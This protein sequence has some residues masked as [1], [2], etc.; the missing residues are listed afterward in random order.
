MNDFCNVQ[1]CAK[2]TLQMGPLRDY[3][4]NIKNLSVIFGSWHLI[5]RTSTISYQSQGCLVRPRL[6]WRIWLIWLV[7]SSVCAFLWQWTFVNLCKIGGILF[8]LTPQ[9]LIGCPCW[10]KGLCVIQ[11]HWGRSFSF[12]LF[13]KVFEW[14]RGH[15]VSK[16]GFAMLMQAFCEATLYGSSRY[17]PV[18][19]KHE[20]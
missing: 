17:I 8:N 11:S 14:A 1:L 16:V 15:P 13:Q 6:V 5:Q 10:A 19:K 18:A 2:L 9:R 3:S 4:G 20:L 12:P 7:A